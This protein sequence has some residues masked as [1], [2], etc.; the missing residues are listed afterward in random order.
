[1]SNTRLKN[2]VPLLNKTKAS[3]ASLDTRVTKFNGVDFTYSEFT[4]DTTLGTASPTVYFNVLDQG[5]TGYLATEV[6]WGD[7]SFEQY[8]GRT[9]NGNDYD[10]TYPANGTYTI[11]W[12]NVRNNGSTFFR[13]QS[14]QD[15]LFSTK[16]TDITQ[17]GWSTGLIPNWSGILSGVN[18]PGPPSA[19]D[20]APAGASISMSLSNNLVDRG[21]SSWATNYKAV[22]LGGYSYNN[23]SQNED[24]TGVTP[25]FSFTA[26][27]NFY[28][29]NGVFNQDVSYNFLDHVWIGSH[30]FCNLGNQFKPEV[31]Y[32]RK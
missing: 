18:F 21:I 8:D 5:G 19:I 29:R 13:N 28:N 17:W 27:G 7:G 3:G 25:D 31:T 14:G 32:E 26:A 4:I 24:W 16:L 6:S 9:G 12:V 11:R 22:R 10:Y 2:G 15:A 30:F 1:M 20:K 23:Q